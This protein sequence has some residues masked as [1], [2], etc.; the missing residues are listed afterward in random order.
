[1][2]A[3]NV[4]KDEHRSYRIDRITG[5]TTTNQTFLPRYAI[6]LSPQGSMAIPQTARGSSGRGVS[7]PARMQSPRRIYQGPVYIYQCPMCNKTFR[8]NRMD[9]HLNPHKNDYGMNCPG[10]IGYLIDTR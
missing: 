2:H 4:D 5:V 10:R 9:G 3:F 8:R 6:E 7:R 1:L